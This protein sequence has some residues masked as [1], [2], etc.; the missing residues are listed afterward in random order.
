MFPDLL[1]EQ[2]ERA[3]QDL[4]KLAE[5]HKDEDDKL[6][7]EE[8]EEHLK[9]V[10]LILTQPHPYFP[11]LPMKNSDVEELMESQEPRVR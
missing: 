7:E 5:E 9:P 6:F 4:E 3:I 11:P 8:T 1:N 10:L 2:R